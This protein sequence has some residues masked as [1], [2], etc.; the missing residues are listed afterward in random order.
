MKPDVTIKY[1]NG[2]GSFEGDYIS[3]LNIDQMREQ[4]QNLE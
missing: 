2:N 4:L 1:P 3:K